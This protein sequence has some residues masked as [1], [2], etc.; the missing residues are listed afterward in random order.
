MLV[1][2]LD[3]IVFFM[4]TWLSYGTYQMKASEL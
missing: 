1:I 4:K 3:L 2:Y